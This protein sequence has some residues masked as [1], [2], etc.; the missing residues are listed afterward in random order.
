[1]TAIAV[2][3]VSSIIL[4]T[5]FS[6]DILFPCIWETLFSINC[7]G[8]GLT[9]ALIKIVTFDFYSAYLTNPLISLVLPIGLFCIIS[10]FYKFTNGLNALP[11]KK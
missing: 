9:T 2:Y 5:V 7:P 10:D 3:F 11:T 8:C 1:M 6:V 4:K